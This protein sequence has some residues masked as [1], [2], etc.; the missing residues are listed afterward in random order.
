MAGRFAEAVERLGSAERHQRPDRGAALANEA[1]VAL[2]RRGDPCR[3][4]EQPPAPPPS[5]SLLNSQPAR[6][7]M[8]R[9]GTPVTMAAAVVMGLE[10]RSGTPNVQE[11]PSKAAPT[12]AWPTSWR[13]AGLQGGMLTW[14]TPQQCRAG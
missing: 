5:A 7:P 2:A 12:V 14:S 9:S 10:P 3:E 4:S 11:T 1:H 8:F 13:R 6:N